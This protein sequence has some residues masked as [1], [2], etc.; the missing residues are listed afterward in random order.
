M[1]IPSALKALW[2]SQA[3]SLIGTDL[4]RF[5]V[6]IWVFRESAGGVSDFAWLTVC[7]ETPAV[8]LSPITGALVDRAACRGWTR[9][10]L[11]GADLLALAAS[12]FLFQR[13]A[14]GALTVSHVYTATAVQSMANSLQ[15]PTFMAA[16]SRLMP[17]EKLVQLGAVY[18]P[19]LTRLC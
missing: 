5:A 8:L 2:A 12:M 1:P 13:Y 6:G 7:A 9:V 11:W 15:W 10:L 16:V 3:L 4:T 18:V 14:T 17:Q 19:R